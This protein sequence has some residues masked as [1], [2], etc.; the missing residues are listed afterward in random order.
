LSLPRTMKSRNKREIIVVS[1][2]FFFKKKKKKKNYI[3]AW[4]VCEQ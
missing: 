1:K 2:N 3:T 4:G